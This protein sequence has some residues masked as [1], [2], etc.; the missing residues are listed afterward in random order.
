MNRMKKIFFKVLFVSIFFVVV[1]LSQA[2]F[3]LAVSESDCLNKTDLTLGEMDECINVILPRIINA[4]AP[5]QKKNKEEL[6]SLRKQLNDLE[7]R[8]AGISNQLF[9]VEKDIEKREEDLAYAQ[10]IFEEKANNHYKFIRLYDPIMPFISADDASSAFRE[11]AL[12]QKATAE[13]IRTMEGYAEDLFELKKDK[14]NLNKNKASLASLEKQVDERADFLAGEVEKVEEYISELSSRQQSLLAARSGAFNV[15][16]G[17]S[18]SAIPC[19]GRPGSEKYCHPGS[20][21]YAAFSFG[22]W[23]HRKGMSQFGA[24]GRAKSGQGFEQILSHYYPGSSLQTRG[25]LPSTI[26]TDQGVKSFE[27]NYLYG[28]AEMPSDWTD[29]NSAALKAQ[30]IAARTYAAYYIGWPGG[31]KTICTSQSCQVYLASKA[32]SPPSEWKQAVDATRGMV[33]LDGGGSPVGAFYS[34]TPGGYLT[35]SGWDTTDGGGGDLFGKAYDN[36][37]SSPWFYSGWYTQSYTSSSAKCGRGGPWLTSEEMADILNAFVILKNT[38]D[39]RIIPET[40]SSCPIDGAGG[41]PYSKEE[42]RN[43]ASQFETAITSVSGVTS[44]TIGGDGTTQSLSFSTNRG[45]FPVDG[46]SFKTAF[47]LRAPGHIAI[48][49]SM[50]N[51]E[52]SQ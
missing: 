11:I 4:Y 37:A 26:S 20:N 23:T 8:I 10:E 50:F 38:N 51:V 52:K 47:N 43:R 31:A 32:S 24:W 34:S 35:T 28:I 18:I 14:E 21:Y 19:S 15:S 22:A 16:A 39:D 9:A 7:K 42:M 3:T 27:E 41:N 12:R 48:R 33:L 49:S 36:I 44:A 5:A 29:N 46:A 45:S 25:D 6:A 2:G 13:D 1:Y 40:I 17:S 30:A